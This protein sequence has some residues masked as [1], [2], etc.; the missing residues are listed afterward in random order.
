MSGVTTPFVPGLRLCGQFYA[1]AV[2]P[3]IDDACP[4]LRYAAARVGPG[5]DVLGFD[6]ERSTDHDWGP[7]LDVFLDPD[8]L[9]RHSDRLSH[10]LGD[11]LPRR[12][13]GYSTHFVPPDARVRVPAD[14]DGPVA[15]LVRFTDV[16]SWCAGHLGFD[17]RAGVGLLDWLG[18]PGQRFAEVTGGAVFR[19]DTGA[20]TAVRRAV[21]WY[22]DD[23]WRFVLAAQWTRIAQEE[24]FV[25]RAAEAGDEVGARVTTARLARDV[26][27]LCLLL[28][29]RHTPYQKWLGSAVATLPEA[30]GVVA[31]LRRAVRAGDAGVAQ[32]ALCDAYEAAGGWQNRLGLAPPVPATRRLFFDRP[33]PVIG[34]DRFATALRSAVTDP[35]IAALPPVGAVDQ[36]VDSTDVLTSPATAR[37]VAAAVLLPGAASSA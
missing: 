10:L 16:G 1:E 36:F 2:R 29:R 18:T 23:V 11:R 26:S 21:H 19:D 25:G 14:T 32:D 7:R 4:G 12:F 34:A 15:H 5:S 3:L 27:R 17:P 24:A 35:T 22:P 33:Y 31:A 8:D 28:G 9:A 30:T 37:A 13:R 6:T 20:L